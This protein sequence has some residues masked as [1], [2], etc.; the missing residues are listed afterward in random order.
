[1]VAL[2]ITWMILA[3]PLALEKRWAKEGALL[4]LSIPQRDPDTGGPLQ[5]EALP[6]VVLSEMPK[7]PSDLAKS[8]YGSFLRK[9]GYSISTPPAWPRELRCL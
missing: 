5:Q 7:L 1:M 9:F 6:K 3:R 2:V 8:K 4:G